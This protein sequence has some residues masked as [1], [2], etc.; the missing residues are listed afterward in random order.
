MLLLLSCCC[1]CCQLMICCPVKGDLWRDI[2]SCERW[3]R[4]Q[5][6]GVLSCGFCFS[7]GVVAKRTKPLFQLFKWAYLH[8]FRIIFRA[9]LLL[10]LVSLPLSSFGLLFFIIILEDEDPHHHL[11]IIS[12]AAEC[13]FQ[14]SN[15]LTV[16]PRDNI[17]ARDQ[18][19]NENGRF[20][21]FLSLSH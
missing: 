1:S 6:G 21:Y 16:P 3:E 19:Q 12:P 10:D 17:Y 8:K 18:Y 2:Q 9:V 4:G 13:S 20:G 5:D 15:C 14:R 11:S 7:V